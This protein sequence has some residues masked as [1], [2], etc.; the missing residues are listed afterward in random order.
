MKLSELKAANKKFREND[1]SSLWPIRGR[2][3]VAERTI[4]KAR[5]HRSET[6]EDLDVSQYE[7]LLD[8]IASEIV[9]NPR[10]W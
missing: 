5:W 6:G 1:D 2:F 7:A 10:N 8:S 3:S 4:K 9:N